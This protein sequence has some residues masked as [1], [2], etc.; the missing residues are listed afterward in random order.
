[1]KMHIHVSQKTVTWHLKNELQINEDKIFFLPSSSIV[2]LS[3]SSFSCAEI[4]LATQLHF[5]HVQMYL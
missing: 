2:T 1:M 5:D 3:H 4:S